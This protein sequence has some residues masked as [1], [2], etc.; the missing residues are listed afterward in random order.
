VIVRD[1]AWIPGPTRFAGE[2]R[3]PLNDVLRRHRL[4]PE[5]GLV[6]S[7]TMRKATGRSRQPTLADDFKMVL[8]LGAELRSVRAFRGSLPQ[9]RSQNTRH[10]RGGILRVGDLP[11]EGSDR[12]QARERSLAG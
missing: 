9:C 8:G 4:G 5:N 1:A 10:E 3:D 7:G 2:T 6:D 11:G 12:S